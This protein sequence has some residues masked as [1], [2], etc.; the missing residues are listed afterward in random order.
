MKCRACKTRTG[1]LLILSRGG[2][3]RVCMQCH[4]GALG[5]MLEARVKAVLGEQA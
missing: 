3:H 2:V 1:F 5:R 4:A